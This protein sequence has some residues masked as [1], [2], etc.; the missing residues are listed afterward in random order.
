MPAFGPPL[1]RVDRSVRVF[2]GYQG[3]GRGSSGILKKSTMRKRWF[4]ELAAAI[5]LC[6]GLLPAQTPAP[7]LTFDVAAIKLAPPLDP[8]KIMAGKMH[9]GMNVNAARVD[10]GN[11]SLAD[12]IRMA[13]KIKSY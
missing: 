6:C 8:A 11:L 2:Q 1:G 5:A 3:C 13:Y 12:L 7:T 4:L 10:I 9:I